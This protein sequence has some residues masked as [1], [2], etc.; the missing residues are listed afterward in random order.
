MP[1]SVSKPQTLYDKVL[2]NHIV[3]EKL[4]GTLLLYIGTSCTLPLL[5]KIDGGVNAGCLHVL[6][7]APLSRSPFGT[8]SHVTGTILFLR[9]SAQFVRHLRLQK[10][11]L[12]RKL[13]K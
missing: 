4:D 8:R 6:T 2:S 10:Q 7:F 5:D 12:T 3:D 13:D 11:K 1:E 9:A